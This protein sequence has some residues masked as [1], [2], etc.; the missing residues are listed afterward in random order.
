MMNL[1]VTAKTV[2]DIQTAFR[3]QTVSALTAKVH[4][5]N[6]CFHLKPINSLI[7]TYAF[8][9]VLENLDP[10]EVE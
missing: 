4:R 2:L 5:R 9:R 6:H 7:F 10:I 1:N 3:T 8:R